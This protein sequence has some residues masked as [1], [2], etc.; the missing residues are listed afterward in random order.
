MFEFKT[1]ELLVSG[2]AMVLTVNAIISQQVTT[3]V[4]QSDEIYNLTRYSE[5]LEKGVPTHVPEKAP[6]N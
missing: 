1:N 2:L 5:I 3:V 6:N 4:T